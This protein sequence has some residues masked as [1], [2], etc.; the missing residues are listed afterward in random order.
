MPEAL[1]T[2]LG[3]SAICLFMYLWLNLMIAYGSF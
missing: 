2:I 3:L 1:E